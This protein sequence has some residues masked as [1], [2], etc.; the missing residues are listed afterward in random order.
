MVMK[1]LVA[2]AVVLA[3]AAASSAQPVETASI[4]YRLVPSKSEFRFELPTTFHLVRCKISEFDGEI[5]LPRDGESARVR[6]TVPT[7]TL[8]TGNARRDRNMETQVLEADRYP[9]IVFEATSV[10]GDF[11]EL[12]PGNTVTFQVAGGLTIHGRSEPVQLPI[13][14]AVF[15]DHVL[16][17]GSFPLHWGDWGLKNPSRFFNRVKDTMTVIFRFWAEPVH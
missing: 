8:E 15:P 16:V 4:R 10:T 13:D 3:F 17:V 5:V 11:G 1:R 9:Q 2:V 12:K 14:V 6:V 7:A